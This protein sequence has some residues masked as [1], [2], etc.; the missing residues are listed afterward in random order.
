[1]PVGNDPPTQ[2]LAFALGILAGVATLILFVYAF[3]PSRDSDIVK[4]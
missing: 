2:R 4:P 1:M 3:Q